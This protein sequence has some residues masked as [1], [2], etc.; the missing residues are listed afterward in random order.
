MSEDARIE[1]LVET[2]QIT[3]YDARRMHEHDATPQR[4]GAVAV[5]RVVDRPRCNTP[6]GSESPDLPAPA[7][8]VVDRAEFRRNAE[9]AHRDDLIRKLA[10]ASDKE[11]IW[12]LAKERIRYERLGGD[13]YTAYYE[14]VMADLAAYVAS[15]A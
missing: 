3:P 5:G 13:S 10:A 1:T 11:R 12:I 14:S 6:H 15:D 8:V 9:Q 7:S 4:A 2:G